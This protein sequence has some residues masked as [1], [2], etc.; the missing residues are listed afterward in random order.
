MCWTADWVCGSVITAD[1][2]PGQ[3]TVRSAR[4][5]LSQAGYASECRTERP[6][7]RLD[8]G[9]PAIFTGSSVSQRRMAGKAGL[10]GSI[11][12]FTPATRGRHADLF[13][14]LSDVG[15]IVSWMVARLERRGR[16][17]A[18]SGALFDIAPGPDGAPLTL[19][20]ECRTS[21][22]A[23]KGALHEVTIE[24]DWAVSTPHDIA[25]ERVAAA[26]GGYTS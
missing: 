12:A 17:S 23:R 2:R 9:I 19:E 6:R 10:T 20:I 8:G 15:P 5:G 18:P 21:P 3:G 22:R 1:Q 11:D 26:F 16:R 4:E 25:A 7:E 24:P 13:G 14:A